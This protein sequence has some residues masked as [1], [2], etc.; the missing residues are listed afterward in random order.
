MLAIFILIPP[1]LDVGRLVIGVSYCGR[2]VVPQYEC[3]N[4]RLP[5]VPKLVKV[6]ILGIIFYWQY[7]NMTEGRNKKS[8]P[9]VGAG[10]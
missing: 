3:N 9:R 8:L 10:D 5:N 6:R 2:I 4:N 1:L 7:H